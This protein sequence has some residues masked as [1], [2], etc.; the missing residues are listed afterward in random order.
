MIEL[1]S[2]AEYRRRLDEKRLGQKQAIQQVAERFINQLVETVESAFNNNRSSVTVEYPKDLSP[3]NMS[4]FTEE[5]A[6]L[7]RPLGY[8]VTQ[9]HDGGGIYAMLHISWG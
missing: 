7:L 4:L 5:T 3:D 1:K 2:P 6:M 8:K 9:T